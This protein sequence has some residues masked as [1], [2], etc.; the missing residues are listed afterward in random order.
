MPKIGPFKAL[1]FKIPTQ[2]TE[3][4]YIASVDHTIED[5]K[6]LL[7]EIGGDKLSLDNTD[8]DTGRPTHIGEYPLSDAAVARL[9][10]QLAQHNF[11]KV[12]P[13]LRKSIL[14]FYADPLP[15]DPSKGHPD[16]WQKTQNQL[17]RLKT[18]TPGEVPPAQ[19]SQVPSQF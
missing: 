16:A 4:L 18:F 8:F 7:L 17:Q 6:G 15:A 19:V 10:D 13:E 11:E 3:D 14:A 9:L 5:Y 1:D 12:T 2:K